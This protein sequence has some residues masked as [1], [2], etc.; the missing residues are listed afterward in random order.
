MAT[1]GKSTRT[2][3]QK[4]TPRKRTA[5]AA[6]AEVM[7]EPRMVEF[8]SIGEGVR[9]PAGRYPA[10]GCDVEPGLSAGSNNVPCHGAG[11][12]PDE[13]RRW[14]YAPGVGLGDHHCAARGEA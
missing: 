11:S 8:R 6:P 7:E 1:K 12:P 14:R 5:P 13:V 2:T 3:K 9:L 4:T 10:G